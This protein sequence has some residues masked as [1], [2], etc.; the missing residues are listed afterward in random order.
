MNL[1]A[2]QSNLGDTLLNVAIL[3][4]N[5]VALEVLLKH[6]LATPSILAQPDGKGRTPLMA[7]C[8]VGNLALV[9]TLLA[10][11]VPI[12][13]ADAKGRLAHTI[14]CDEAHTDILQALLAATS[15]SEHIA[16]L[17]ALVAH[18][19]TTNNMA[20]TQT[21]LQRSLGAVR[22]LALVVGRPA[23]RRLSASGADSKPQPAASSVETLLITVCLQRVVRK[24]LATKPDRESFLMKREAAVALQRAWRRRAQ[25]LSAKQEL[26]RLRQ[27]RHLALLRER[28]A[29]AC[30]LGDAA[31]FETAFAE[32]S[33]MDGADLDPSYR[34]LSSSAPHSSYLLHAISSGQV[35]LA[36]HMLVTFRPNLDAHVDGEG[37]NVFHLLAEHQG[38]SEAQLSPF[39]ADPF[40]EHAILAHNSN[41]KSPLSICFGKPGHFA[42][43]DRTLQLLEAGKVPLA[44]PSA[45]LSAVENALES[46]A[47][48]PAVA[49][50][51]LKRIRALGVR[52]TASSFANFAERLSSSGT[53]SAEELALISESV[54]SQEVAPVALFGHLA[55]GGKLQAMQ[56]VVAALGDAV[57]HAVQVRDFRAVEAISRQCFG[58]EAPVIWMSPV[59]SP[60]GVAVVHH[61]LPIIRW[62]VHSLKC[63]VPAHLFASAASQCF[64]A[65]DH[66]LADSLFT[67]AL[68]TL[69]PYAASGSSAW[70]GS[71]A[72]NLLAQMC[73]V[74]QYLARPEL[75]AIL[76]DE[77]LHGY[78]A[79]SSSFSSQAT[80]GSACA[81]TR[82]LVRCRPM[83]RAVFENLINQCAAQL[84]R[85]TSDLGQ[86]LEEVLTAI[87]IEDIVTQDVFRRLAEMYVKPSN[88]IKIHIL[89]LLSRVLARFDGHQTLANLARNQFHAVRFLHSLGGHLLKGASTAP[90]LESA[91]HEFISK[92]FPDEHRCFI[93]LDTIRNGVYSKVESG[94]EHFKKGKCFHV[95]C[96]DCMR[97]YIHSKIQD[98]C[99]SIRCPDGSCSFVLY[100]DDIG[101]IADP[102]HVALYAK[103]SKDEF[104]S[105][106]RE[107]QVLKKDDQ[108]IASYIRSH[109]RFCPSCKVL[110]E[111][112]EGCSSMLCTCGHR[113]DWNSA[114]TL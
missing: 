85:I 76:G 109:C 33:A 73:Q 68:S 66:E 15:P 77:H 4:R 98:R 26:L 28:L 101:R 23:S 3:E 111:R 12:D 106:L 58:L 96:E 11:K 65:G 9:N 52:W 102:P 54:L 112:S 61:H 38:A 49:P 94:G 43:A 20:C 50:S 114:K 39:F 95:F 79:M 32:L 36:C 103:L 91:V 45:V 93:C 24:W 64:A 16:V 21:L 5:T 82:A 8:K 29:G 14:A 2:A 6:K 89:K 41:G 88:D 104:V 63:S 18:L 13:A 31:T 46:A 62:L 19:I 75:A 59:T 107:L 53:F 87:P 7:A 105:R 37:N 55:K 81:V 80:T 17:R 34:L 83:P 78:L 67:N 72:L 30:A 1:M 108:I 40:A 84:A 100:K 48:N 35:A 70:W 44:R 110:I 27:A 97:G 25:V 57:V 51:T 22:P 10:A 56:Q 69:P 71:D 113:F 90:A 86:T 92:H 99:T 74:P 47:A 60:L 42:F